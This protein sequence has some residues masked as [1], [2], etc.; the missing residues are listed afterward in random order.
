MISPENSQTERNT[1]ML[2]G[3]LTIRDAA[4]LASQIKDARTA[5]APLR[6]DTTSVERLDV[7]ILQ[8]IA[9]ASMNDART[10]AATVIVAPD[11][12][13]FHDAIRRAG[14]EHVFVNCETA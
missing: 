14:M 4:G 12:G 10:S 9:A 1:I 8:L 6:I 3:D 2:A 5:D 13:V 11:N 7:A